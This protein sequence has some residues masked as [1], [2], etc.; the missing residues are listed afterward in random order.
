MVF[1]VDGVALD[2]IYCFSKSGRGGWLP[3][4]G[5]GRCLWTNPNLGASWRLAKE[6]V[7]R[8]GILIKELCE[9]VLAVEF[10][11]EYLKER[12]FAKDIEL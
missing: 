10:L 6:R 2:D 5:R 7:P 4:T 8:Q 9:A 3:M 1:F 12:G 11:K